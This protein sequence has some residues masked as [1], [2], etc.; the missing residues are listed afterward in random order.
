[1]ITKTYTPGSSVCRATFLFDAPLGVEAVSICGDFNR[2]TPGAH[3]MT[4]DTNGAFTATLPLACGERFH[5]KYLLDNGE[6][7]ND[8]Q[9]DAYESNEWGVVNSILDTATATAPTDAIFPPP[10]LQPE[11]TAPRPETPAEVVPVKKP[12]R[13][14]AA[15]A[16]QA[17]RKAASPAVKAV[18]KK[19]PAKKAPARKPTKD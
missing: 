16:A 11:A 3:T 9:A 6:W 7:H 4:R 10:V 5:F 2:W 18:A 17:A 12:S 13:R 8:H 15:P 19:A 1:M 14:K